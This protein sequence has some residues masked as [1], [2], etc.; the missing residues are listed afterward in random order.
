VSKWSS[1]RYGRRRWLVAV[2][3]AAV[4]EAAVDKGIAKIGV[5]EV[6]AE[7]LEPQ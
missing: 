1:T 6:M 5:G 4:V 3:V 2:V 7:S